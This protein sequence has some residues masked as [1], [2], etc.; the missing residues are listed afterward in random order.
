MSVLLVIP[1][2]GG[3]V[4]IP[5]KAL[6][7]LGGI[8]A[9]VRLIRTAQET[10]HRIVV[11]SDDA[12]VL[13]LA[14]L[15]GVETLREPAALNPA[16]TRSLDAAVYF[17]VRHVARDETLIVTLQATSPFTTVETLR[18]CISLAEEYE[19]C[20]TVRDDRG[21]RWTTDLGTHLTTRAPYRLTRQ[22]MPPC[23][24]ETG[25]VVATQRRYV[26]PTSRFGHTVHLVEVRGAEAVDLDAPEDWAV[27]EWYA[28]APSLRE[29]LMARVLADRFPPS[30]AIVLR[31]SAWDEE[32][33]DDTFREAAVAKLGPR[34]IRLNDANT[35]MEA[36]SGISTVLGLPEPWQPQDVA[37][38][39]SAYHQPRAFLT[40]LRVLQDKGLDRTLRLWNVAAASRLDKFPEEWRKITTYQAQG[41]VASLEDGLAY[42]DWRARVLVP[43]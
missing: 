33:D 19:T 18:R 17:A 13:D 12:E 43:A 15:E 11:T 4:G 22:Q 28:G 7:P 30:G 5:R 38:V 2:R 31:F 34:V 23:W 36:A 1:V 14:N 3:S 6:K 29:C 10:G 32:S 41:H 37:L 24:R 8:P 42:L 21:L 9:L 16:G 35:Y 25:A 40:C 20:V 39:T 26:T 27:A